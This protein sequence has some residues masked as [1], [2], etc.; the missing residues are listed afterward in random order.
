VTEETHP[1]YYVTREGVVRGPFE[2]SLIEAMV[3]AGHFPANVLVLKNGSMDWYPLSSYNRPPSSPPVL[4]V[5]KEGNGMLPW[6]KSPLKITGALICLGLLILIVA[7]NILPPSKQK[8]E[9]I[10][11]GGSSRNKSAKILPAS[12]RNVKSYS[13]KEIVGDDEK[14]VAYSAKEITGN[15]KRV[16]S[17]SAKEL[18]GE[19]EPADSV[20]VRSASGQVYRVSRSDHERLSAK[21]AEIQSQKRT[22][23]LDKTSIESLGSQIE[24]MRATLDR[25]SQYSVDSFNQKVNEYNTKNDLMKTRVDRFNRIV[26][27]YNTELERVGRPIR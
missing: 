14:F 9:R 20:S 26:E 10:S 7:L 8:E 24:L 12:E 15:D 4:S 11:A 17:Y 18:A 21:E 16:V 13:Y 19:D 22:I 25:T 23:D 6:W 2:L 27:E 1:R 3:L 5:N